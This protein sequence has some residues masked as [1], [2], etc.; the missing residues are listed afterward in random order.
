MSIYEE[1]GGSFSKVNGYMI[2][3]LIIANSATI[4]KWGRMRKQ[5]LKAHRPA[6]FSELLL[7]E[8]LYEHCAEVECACEE[9]LELLVRQMS[10]RKGVTEALKAADQMDWVRRMNSIRSRAE[11]IVLHELIFT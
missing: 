1:A 9:W 8:K 5:Y 6:V 4:G 3:D 2:P 7:A 11:E 10:E